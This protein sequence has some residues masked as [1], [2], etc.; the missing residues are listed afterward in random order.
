[1][2]FTTNWYVLPG[3]SASITHH[4]FM[5]SHNVLRDVQLSQVVRK[6]VVKATEC[7]HEFV[8]WTSRCSVLEIMKPTYPKEEFEML[9]WHDS[10]IKWKGVDGIPHI[11]YRSTIFSVMLQDQ[12]G[13]KL[14]NK[15]ASDQRKIIQPFLWARCAFRFVNRCSDLNMR[16][17]IV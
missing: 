4:L 2:Y 6:L 9:L 3:G 13:P 7:S 1:M 17:I 10:S 11:L 8:L 14:Q 5:N 15:S 16:F 12:Q